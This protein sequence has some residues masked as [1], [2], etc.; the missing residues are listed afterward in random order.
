MAS[1]HAPH[2]ES[3]ERSLRM[4]LC[5]GVPLSTH[6][7]VSGWARTLSIPLSPLWLGLRS[8]SF[9]LSSASVSLLSWSR[10]RLWSCVCVRPSV[11]SWL[12]LC[13]ISLRLPPGWA[14]TPPVGTV[15]PC[16]LGS[17]LAVYALVSLCVCCLCW[18]GPACL[19]QSLPGPV[20][21]VCLSICVCPDCCWLSASLVTP[22]PLSGPAPSGGL[23][24]NGQA[25]RTEGKR[26]ERKHARQTVKEG[27]AERG[28]HGLC[29]G[30]PRLTGWD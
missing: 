14:R 19:C 4:H 1:G 17:S 11:C 28:H 5:P 23:T 26:V 30:G 25:R 7:T 13:V 6:A 16:S 22:C 12:P 2:A 15:P 8:M 21:V 18:F 27:C 20:R 3:A 9:C 10:G 24:R 29:D